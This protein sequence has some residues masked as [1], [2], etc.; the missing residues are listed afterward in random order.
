MAWIKALAAA[1]PVITEIKMI[2]S[3]S[4]LLPFTGGAQTTASGIRVYRNSGNSYEAK[5]S[6][7]LTDMNTLTCNFINRSGSGYAVMAVDGTN[8]GSS[9]SSSGTMT[10]SVASYTGTHEVKLY[11]SEI[12]AEFTAT[13]YIATA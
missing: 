12:N 8:V 11:C 4:A 10:G 9:N 3:G 2:E 6:I 13:D 7:D 1:I 5:F